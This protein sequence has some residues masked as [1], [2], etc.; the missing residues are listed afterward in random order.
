MSN[1]KKTVKRLVF[2][3]LAVA[4]YMLLLPLWCRLRGPALRI[5]TYHSVSDQRDHETNVSPSTFEDHVAFLARHAEI[6]DL[7]EWAL[8]KVVRCGARKPGI[9]I[10]FD[11][12]YADNLLCAAPILSK[13]GLSATC[14]LT[15]AYIGTQKLL[16]HDA[17]SSV[18]AC[19]LLTWPQVKELV[20]QGC[21]MG[22]HGLS[23]ARFSRLSDVDLETEIKTSKNIIERE[24]GREICLI[25]YPYGRASDVDERCDRIAREAGYAAA[26]TACYGENHK[27]GRT[28]LKRIGIDASDTL[29]TLRAKMNGALDMLLL[30]EQPVCRRAIERV[31]RLLGAAPSNYGAERS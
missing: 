4:G 30:I 10:T 5:F 7:E 8:G 25:S 24:I 22:S 15:V 27:A 17:R 2:H 28:P 1:S 31:N 12:G 19:R 11:D 26:A 16:P 3:L 6:L 23:H 20:G 21:S 18:E 14:F 29:F 9:A 13:H